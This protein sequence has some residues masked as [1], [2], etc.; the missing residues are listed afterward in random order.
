MPTTKQNVATL[1]A[2]LRDR[3][4]APSTPEAARAALALDADDV[5][6][7]TWHRR[8]DE[9]TADERADLAAADE[10]EAEAAADAGQPDDDEAQA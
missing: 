9:L 4:F 7:R 1:L 3:G 6:G 10:A 8:A 2:E 5:L